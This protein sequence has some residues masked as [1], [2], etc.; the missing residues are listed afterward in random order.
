MFT[1]PTVTDFKDFFVRDFPYGATTSTIMDA[2]ILR[3]I[4]EAGITINPCFF[5]SQGAYQIGFLYLAAHFLV[6]N[7]RNSSQGISGNYEWLQSSKSVGS[8]SEGISIPQ[9]ILEN[10]AFA[11]LSKTAYGAKYL[12]LILPQLSGNVFTVQGMTKP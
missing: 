4:T 2:D 6:T 11:M 12:Y 8:V 5:T 3:A 7:I 10:P 9:R 1:N